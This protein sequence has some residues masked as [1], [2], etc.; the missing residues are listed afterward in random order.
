MESARPGLLDM[1]TRYRRLLAMQ[2]RLGAERNLERLAKLAT[3]E[4]SELLGADRS[5]LFRLDWETMQLSACHAE[6]VQEGLIVPLR[7]G[8][9]GTA[10]IRRRVV[11]VVGAYQHP[12]FNPEIDAATGYMTDSLLAIPI[13]ADDGRVLG[14]LE[15]LNSELG[16]FSPE[17]EEV[18]LAVADHFAELLT[19]PGSGEEL[20]RALV[21]SE[22]ALLHLLVPF[23]RASLFLLDENLGQLSAYY[24]DGV[25]AQSLDMKL[26]LKVGIAGMVAIT[27][28]AVNVQD[29]R[30]DG[31]FTTVFDQ[32]TGY[33]TRNMLCVPLLSASGEPLGVLQALNKRHG[34]FT[35]DDMEILASIAGVV[36]VELEN[37]LLFHDSERQFRSLIEV[38]AASIDARDTLTA[39]H[40]R[41]VAQIAVAIGRRLG[42]AEPELD[43]L[44]VA[45]ILHDYGKIGVD[46]AVLRK[47]GK[48][49]EEEFTAMKRHASST[50]EILDKIYFSRK[51]RGV[52]LIASS[53]HEYP[54]GSG[55][56]RG[57][58]GHEIPFMSKI[59]TVADF[60]EAMTAK[61]HYRSGVT[62]MQVLE[63]LE[64]GT[65][66]RFDAAVVAALRQ[67]VESEEPNCVVTT[68]P[69][70]SQ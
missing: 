27:G 52:P 10:I 22:M 14:G 8:L 57:L 49:N 2:K 61:R 69:A 17:E 51:Y 13:H 55:Y 70:H 9:I 6:G 39:G 23:H 19:N 56:P 67:C 59:I 3:A 11:N 5:T 33:V 47:T 50:Y 68:V 64:E 18:A 46:D 25:E 4:A 30:S 48:L 45:A 24:A 34:S 15:L 26:S 53:H 12:C 32:K 66:E 29:V 35:A 42:F 1:Q 31:R 62:P 28:E 16:R 36:G 60:F 63:I 43:V 58:V 21:S 54:D 38:L 65:G 20:D 7:M 41:R 37:T 40:S 44:Q